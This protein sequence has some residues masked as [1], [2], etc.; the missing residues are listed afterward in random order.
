[1]AASSAPP[2]ATIVHNPHGRR[3]DLSDVRDSPSQRI[4]LQPISMNGGIHAHTVQQQTNPLKPYSPYQ[5]ESITK[6][7]LASNTDSASLRHALIESDSRPQ[8]MPRRRS[9]VGLPTHLRLGSSGY[10]FWPAHK[11]K[12][13]SGARYG[14]SETKV[15]ILQKATLIIGPRQWITVTEAIST[16]ILPLPY[17][18]ASL[19]YD[20]RSIRQQFEFQPVIHRFS[21]HTFE[22]FFNG[23]LKLVSH[24]PGASFAWMLASL[25]LLLIEVKS[26][27]NSVSKSL[28]RRKTS[29]GHSHESMAKPRQFSVYSV[30]RLLYKLLCVGLPFYATTKVGADRVILIL[31][32]TISADIMSSENEKL[33]LKSLQRW[34]RLLIYRR[35]SLAA[36][37][38]PI[39]F[40]ML[41]FSSRFSLSDLGRG[42]LALSLS[43]FLLPPP[44]LSFKSKKPTSAYPFAP[45]ITSNSRSPAMQKDNRTSVKPTLNANDSL[46]RAL[47]DADF[48]SNAGFILIMLFLILLFSTTSAG[49]VLPIEVF[50]G[51][52]AASAAAFSFQFVQTNSMRQ[53]SSLGLLI[54]SVS[55]LLIMVIARRNSWT[56]IAFQ[57]AFVGISFLAIRLDAYLSRNSTTS[58]LEP[59]SRRQSPYVNKHRSHSKGPSKI[60]SF[61]LQVFHNWPLLHSI[62]SEKDSRRIL[63]FMRYAKYHA[64]DLLLIL[65]T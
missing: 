11:Q 4:L 42:Y 22:A 50:F 3:N 35:W 1:M 63:Y 37:V 53:N 65:L 31:L 28:D 26:K 16:V 55:S 43:I 23:Y 39:L 14:F 61:L 47:Q 44:F 19:A 29:S 49:A 8:S 57:V 32:T 52:L 56:S 59:Q 15:T 17:I 27:M 58:R 7:Q 18:L 2:T 60:S 64:L 6:N 38:L 9:S 41:K 33:P 5:S 25:T 36:L 12:F 21:G 46:T 45:S 51:F 30:R 13:D 40:D 20:A 34:K 10:G 62:L 54:G 48:T 24:H